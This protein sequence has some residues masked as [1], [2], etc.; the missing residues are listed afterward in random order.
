M[1]YRAGLELYQPLK[2]KI[3]S[4]LGYSD[5][6]APIYHYGLSAVCALSRELSSKSFLENGFEPRCIGGKAGRDL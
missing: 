3:A 2:V 1:S 5:V 4:R 6:K